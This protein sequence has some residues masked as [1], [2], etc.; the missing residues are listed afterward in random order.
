MKDWNE[1]AGEMKTLADYPF[2]AKLIRS[3]GKGSFIVSAR[4]MVSLHSI[5]MNSATGCLERV[6]A[7]VE[8][9]RCPIDKDYVRAHIKMAGTRAKPVEGGSEVS[10]VTMM[11]PSGYVP[12]MFKSK[13]AKKMAGRLDLMTNAYKKRFGI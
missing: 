2:N 6:S 4:D 3:I 13:M 9:P 5:T 12:D 11:N 1:H 10:I 8:D 7:S